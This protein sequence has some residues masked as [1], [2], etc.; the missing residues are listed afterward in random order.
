M[1]DNSERHV[2]RSDS[3]TEA[4]DLIEML[5]DDGD[6]A[7]ADV[8][9]ERERQEAKW[10]EQNHDPIVYSAILTEEVGELAQAAIQARYE[11]G[12]EARI[13]EEAVQVAA[14]AL[15]IIECL[16]R[17]KWRWPHPDWMLST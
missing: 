4:I 7:L 3:Y 6:S 12:D 11:G 2:R 15:A 16:D 8:L 10:G 5:R 14:V 1:S 17:G 9:A 13:R